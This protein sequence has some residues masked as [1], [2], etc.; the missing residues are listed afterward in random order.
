M[1]KRLMAAALLAVGVMAAG[2]AAKAAEPLV[3]AAWLKERLGSPGLV[4]LDVR[5]PAEY[6]QAHIPGAVNTDYAK[7]GWRVDRESDKVAEMLPAD[8]GPL[9]RHIGELGIGDAS[10]VVLVHGGRAAGEVGNATRI[11]WTFKVMGHDQVSI[12]DGGF[13]EWAKDKANPVEQGRV[14]AEPRQ[15]PVRLRADMLAGEEDVARAQAS[16]ASL[17]D[18]R[19]EDYYAGINRSGRVKAAGTIP[20]AR[21]LPFTWLTDNAGGVFRTKAQLAAL[22]AA[23][24]VP[25]GGEQI[26][27]CNTG[28]LASIGWFV[29][30][31]L[32]GNGQARLYDGSMAEW[33]QHGHPVERKVALP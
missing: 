30:H 9:A 7:A 29:A 31:D 5:A 14:A 19:S 2:A 27:F 12:L 25:V 1:L 26:L 17:V 11:Y 32:M 16:G 20:G 23:A 4:V 28:H 3:S 10:R 21:N 13:A 8:L 22:Y 6:L 33:A 24:G 15:F 18:A